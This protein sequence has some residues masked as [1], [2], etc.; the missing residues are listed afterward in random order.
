MKALRLHRSRK[1]HSGHF[2]FMRA[3]VQGV[4]ARASWD[5]YLR[6]EG[7][8]VDVRRVR[9]TIAW[10][11][12]EFAAAAVREEK[13]GTARLV[14]LDAQQLAEGGTLLPSLAEFATQRGLEEFS[15]AEQAE[16][17][18]KEFGGAARSLSRRARL[19]ARQLEAL[20]WLESIAAEHPRAG[21]SVHAWLMPSLAARIEA[22]GIPTLFALIERINGIG[23][24][25]WTGV[26]GVGE[27]KARRIVEWL[28]LYET[29]IGMR[30]GGHVATPRAQL[31]PADLALV[32]ASTTALVPLEKFIVPS[33]LSG[34]AGRFRAARDQCLLEAD[35]DYDAIAAWLATK[36]RRQAEESA[37]QRSYRKEAERL[38]LWAVLERQKALS[39]L[40]VE[41]ATAFVAF[42]QAPPSAWCGPRHRQRWSPLWRPLE[43]ALS[44]S[45]LRQTLTILRSFYAFLVDQNYV[46]GNPFT[47]VAQ[48]RASARLLGS[49][50][51]LTID[52]W[53]LVE[54]QLQQDLE[55]STGRRRARAVHWLY[56]TGLRLAEI[57]AARCADLELFEYRSADGTAGSGWLL[58]VEGKGGKLR[59][60]PV[61]LSLVEELGDELEGIG[62]SRDPRAAENHTLPILASFDEGSFDPWS[63]AGIYKAVKVVFERSAE[64]LQGADAGSASRLRLASPHWLRHTHGTHALNGRPGR[65]PVPVQV[66]QN[67]LGHSSIGTTSAYLTTERSGRLQAMEGFWGE[68]KSGQPDHR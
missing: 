25:W 35:N 18:E 63:T 1:L 36:R 24:R 38:L 66:V 54:I 3:V 42:L 30:I 65:A 20:R 48:P 43:G 47:G 45:A 57:A 32:V 46:I 28:Q 44:V 61:P 27:L 34:R 21:D 5:R 9:S 40:T 37:T 7:E 8:H 62:R 2:A 53:E 50:R 31:A 51:S 19:I 12:A 17:Y 52:Q 16:A 22:A 23:S 56:A 67:N 64:Q 11:R 68:G 10:I 29:S 6:L 49:N 60:V 4:D 14:L 33:E 39:S 41:D 58:T 26:Q 13:P 59:Q 15:E 55:T